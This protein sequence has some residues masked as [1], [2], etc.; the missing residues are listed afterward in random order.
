M[1][2]PSKACVAD[3]PRLA[4]FRTTDVIACERARS[5]RNRMSRPVIHGTSH[6]LQQHL[7]PKAQALWTCRRPPAR[8]SGCL[9]STPLTHAPLPR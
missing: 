7:M 5:R 9:V 1:M 6:L 2:G 8:V 3:T 4:T